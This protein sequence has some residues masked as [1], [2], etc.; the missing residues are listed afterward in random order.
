MERVSNIRW[1]VV[2]AV[3][4]LL[5]GCNAVDS[6]S[7][8]LN[9]ETQ[10]DCEAP[11]TCVMGLCV[12]GTADLPDA[13]PNAPDADPNAPENCGLAG[14][15]CCPGDSCLAGA[16]CETGSCVGP[17]SDLANGDLCSGGAATSCGG[18][19][20]VCCAN[21]TCAGAGS[22]CVA[23]SC[24]AN[25]ASC[26]TYGTCTDGACVGGGNVTCGGIGDGCCNGNPNG[27][28][29]AYDF[30]TTPGTVCYEVTNNNEICGLCGGVGQ[31]CCEGILCDGDA[32]CDDGPKPPTCVAS[33]GS[34]SGSDGVCSGGGCLGGTCGLVGQVECPSAGCTAPYT[35]NNNNMCEPC[36]GLGQ[37]C[38]DSENGKFCGS[39]NVCFDGIDKFCEACGAIGQACCL[40]DLCPASGSCNSVNSRCQ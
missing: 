22:C 23:G 16:C 26:G 37:E 17:G 18:D 13:D 36:G 7:G 20:E 24:V 40:G 15:A 3:A 33:G 8:V 1:I 32:C 2:A 11:R 12:L 27:N 38:C 4:T 31:P 9:C 35:E 25:A 39:P 19:G 34:C 29:E 30:C 5:L 6:R 10:A 14:Y 28:G 21:S